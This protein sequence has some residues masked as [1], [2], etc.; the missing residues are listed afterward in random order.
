MQ[1]FC[2]TKLSEYCLVAINYGYHA[3]SN[4]YSSSLFLIITQIFVSDLND[5]F[6]LVSQESW[7]QHATVRDNILFGLPYDA[8]KY[9]TVIYACALEPVSI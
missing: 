6:A 8:N 1:K 3:F 9:N 7:I 5:G 2:A 4:N